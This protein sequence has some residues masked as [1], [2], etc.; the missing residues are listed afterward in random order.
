MKLLGTFLFGAVLL[1]S[2]QNSDVPAQKPGSSHPDTGKQRKP[3]GKSTGSSATQTQA[4]VPQQKPGANHPD[5]ATQR[6]ATPTAPDAT[7]QS[8]ST[9][10][11]K[12]R[13]SHKKKNTT[14]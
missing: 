3:S 10:A 8:K 9:A 2:A 4:D 12:N 5:L 11:K 1:A 13:T 7:G 6:Q 14:T